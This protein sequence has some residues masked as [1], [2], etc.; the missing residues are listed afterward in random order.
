MWCVFTA[1]NRDYASQACKILMECLRLLAFGLRAVVVAKWDEGQCTWSILCRLMTVLLSLEHQRK[2]IEKESGTKDKPVAE[3]EA[4]KTPASAV[5]QGTSTDEEVTSRES[6][7]VHG[8]QAMEGEKLSSP[9]PEEENRTLQQYE[10]RKDTPEQEVVTPQQ[11]DKGEGTPQQDDKGEGTP[12]Q[13]DKGVGTPQQGDKGV[14]TPQQD[15][16]EKEE[17]LLSLVSQRPAEEDARIGA[18]EKTF[19]S[20]AVERMLGLLAAVLPMDMSV[21][22]EIICFALL[23]IVVS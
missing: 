3:G 19:A 12:Q 8:E 22:H 7:A 5:E 16:E 13:G 9:Q 23:V 18:M 15:G 4:E 1:T 14:G 17:D 21:C 11:G 20:L 10:D 2:S 6:V